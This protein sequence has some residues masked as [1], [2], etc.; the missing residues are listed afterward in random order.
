M[1][2]KELNALSVND[3]Q[4]RLLDLKKE[5]LSFR[6]QLATGTTP[7]SPGQVKQTKKTI[8][9]ILTQL[10]KKGGKKKETANE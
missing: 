6:T 1:K 9:R 4:S 2:N 3:L 10:R 5:L 8:A 7:K